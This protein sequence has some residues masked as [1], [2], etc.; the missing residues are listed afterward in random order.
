[1]TLVLGLDIASVLI[2]AITG[3]LVAARA[4]LDV[5]GFIFIAC[6]TAVGGGTT[7][8]L[9]LG[10]EPVFWIGD[11]S[12]VAVSAVVAVAVFFTHHLLPSRLTWI[13]WLD[14]V[15]LSVAAAAG[16]AVAHDMGQDIW[17]QLVMGIVTGCMGG[18]LRDVVCNEVPL[19]L[20]QGELYVTAALAG[21]AA[22]VI[23]RE[24]AAPG[25]WPLAACVF[26]TFLLRAGSIRYGWRL[27]S[28]RARPP[29]A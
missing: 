10:R 11:P 6:L 29:R 15:A 22:G 3:A 21:A 12:P 25:L 20:N 23:A 19:V 24:L 18:L 16:V 5:I 8:D 26:V 14:A 2:F 28:F 1:M 4:Q 27:P 7:R 17:V 9:L 13:V